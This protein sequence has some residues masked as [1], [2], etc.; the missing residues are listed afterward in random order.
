M[1]SQ[2]DEN[3]GRYLPIYSVLDVNRRFFTLL[4]ESLVSQD[5][6]DIAKTLL[7]QANSWENYL[8]GIWPID[9]DI[10]P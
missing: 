1:W 9:L 6:L 4:S 10:I 2:T 8:T 3:K 5:S 7:H